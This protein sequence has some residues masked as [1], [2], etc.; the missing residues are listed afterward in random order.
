[1]EEVSQGQ[2]PVDEEGVEDEGIYQDF[3]KKY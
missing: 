1:V 2:H 3:E